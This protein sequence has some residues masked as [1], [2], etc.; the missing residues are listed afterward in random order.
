MHESTLVFCGSRVAIMVDKAWSYSALWSKAP[1]NPAALS[2]ADQTTP[3]PWKGGQWQSGIHKD[4]VRAGFHKYKN[5]QW[6]GQSW[7]SRIHNPQWPGQ[8]WLSQIYKFTESQRP[9]GQHRLSQR[10]RMPCQSLPGQ[11]GA[12]LVLFKQLFTLLQPSLPRSS[13][14][15]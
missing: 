7:L 12:A 8:G 4:Q 5:S 14:K 13:Y 11:Q 3:I 10:K 6:F 15:Q 2:K 9:L 1:S